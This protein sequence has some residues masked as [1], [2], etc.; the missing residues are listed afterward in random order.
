M[1][2]IPSLASLLL[3]IATSF[4]A[5]AEAEPPFFGVWS[6][7]MVNDGDTI[8]VA[9]WWRERFDD[10]GVLTDGAQKPSKLSVRGLR[11]GVYEVTYADGGKAEIEMKEPWIFVR[12]TNEHRYL[13]LRKSPQ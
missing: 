1:K 6:C 8:D 12:H 5:R 10:K 7:A 3:G 11:P 4:I 9:D 13:C 2:I